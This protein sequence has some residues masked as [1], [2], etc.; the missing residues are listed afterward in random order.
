MGKRI[1]RRRL[2]S[3]L[4]R[5]YDSTCSITRISTGETTYHK[6]DHYGARMMDGRHQVLRIY[7]D[8]GNEI[9]NDNRSWNYLGPDC[10][11][12]GKDYKVCR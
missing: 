9:Y 2:D 8:N 7:L 10:F 3:L 4:E 6:C 12:N 11:E 5:N 1:G